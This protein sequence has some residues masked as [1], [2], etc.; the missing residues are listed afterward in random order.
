MWEG[1]SREVVCESNTAVSCPWPRDNY[2]VLA[3]NET[4]RDRRLVVPL[5]NGCVE[6]I[7][8]RMTII[9]KGCRW[10]KIP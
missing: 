8:C 3:R 7:S 4:R 10:R 1:G 2:L 5:E 9:I 6:G